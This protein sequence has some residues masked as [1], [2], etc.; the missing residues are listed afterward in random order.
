MGGGERPR[1]RRP[2]RD[3]ELGWEAAPFPEEPFEALPFDELHRH[4]R[5]ARG[6]GGVVDRHDVRVLEA[7]GVD[8]LAQQAGGELLALGLAEIRAEAHGLERH[9]PLEL[10]IPAAEDRSHAADAEDPE[11]LIAAEE[12]LRGAV[13]VTQALLEGGEAPLELADLVAPL[14]LTAEEPREAALRGEQPAQRLDELGPGETGEQSDEEERRRRRPGGSP[15]HPQ[16]RRL[17]HRGRLAR[18]HR[19]AAR[20]HRREGAEEGAAAGGGHPAL[21]AHH[22]AGEGGFHEL[23]GPL[24]ER[25][26]GTGEAKAFG[27]DEHEIRLFAE[28]GRLE[29]LVELAGVGDDPCEHPLPGRHVHEEDRAVGALEEHRPHVGGMTVSHGG[30]GAGFRALE[31]RPEQLLAPGRDQR[32][33]EHAA[34]GVPLQARA[35]HLRGGF[36]PQ[37]AGGGVRRHRGGQR[38]AFADERLHPRR[39]GPGRQRV[40]AQHLVFQRLPVDGGEQ[41]DGERERQQPDDAEREADPRQQSE[42]GAGDRMLSVAGMGDGGFRCAASPCWAAILRLGQLSDLL[43]RCSLPARRRTPNHGIVVS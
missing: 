38:R 2:E 6:V 19:P 43:W 27:R 9:R 30:G 15:A 42:A 5:A 4:E 24:G 29:Q 18:E 11:H 26:P 10:R 3:P 20:A 32:D 36:R 12:D 14:R 35:Q 13:P 23:G 33:H 22:L 39:G 41:G 25:C 40:R 16:R 31:L 17:G 28:L 21:R 8:R 37:P 34:V 1:H 7:G